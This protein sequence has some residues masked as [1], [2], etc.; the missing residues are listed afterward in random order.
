MELDLTIVMRVNVPDDVDPDDLVLEVDE[1]GVMTLTSGGE[2]V[3]G[4]EA[5]TD[6]Y[7][8]DYEVVDEEAEEELEELDEGEEGIGGMQ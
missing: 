7:I 6:Y 5:I 4:G 3:A 1:D 8:D 2:V